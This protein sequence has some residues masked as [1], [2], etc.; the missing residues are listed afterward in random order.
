MEDNILWYLFFEFDFL[1][2][3][4]FNDA[5]ETLLLMRKKINGSNSWD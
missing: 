5:L 4:L 1:D 3:Y 2:I